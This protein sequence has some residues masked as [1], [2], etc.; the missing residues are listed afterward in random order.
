ML[1]IYTTGPECYKCKL[2]KDAF[3]KAGVAYTEVR[4]DQA[5]ESVAAKFIAAGHAHAPVVVDALTDVMWSDF[6]R[7]MIKA[8][9]KARA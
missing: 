9:I 4:L 1:T 5:D 6:R 3:D 2:T 8:A 7:D